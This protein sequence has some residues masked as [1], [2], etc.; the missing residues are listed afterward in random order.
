MGIY[1]VLDSGNIV[2][3]V[4]VSQSL[5]VAEDVTQATCILETNST[6]PAII[7]YIYNNGTFSE[8]QPEPEPQLVE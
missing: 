5:N 8:V 2:S 7:G 4:I 1:A 6:G 3:N